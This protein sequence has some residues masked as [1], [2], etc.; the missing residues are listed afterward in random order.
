[1]QMIKG[2]YGA[3]FPFESLVIYSPLQK[4]W[5]LPIWVI[6]ETNNTKQTLS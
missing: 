5:R 3:Y 2:K 4:G 6:L 1:M